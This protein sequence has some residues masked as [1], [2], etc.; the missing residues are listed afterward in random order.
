MTSQAIS[1]GLRDMQYAVQEGL[2]FT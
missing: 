1:F 2:P